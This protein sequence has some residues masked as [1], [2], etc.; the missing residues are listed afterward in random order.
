MIGVIGGVDISHLAVVDQGSIFFCV[1][2]AYRHVVA[3]LTAGRD[4]GKASR[5]PLATQS[6]VQGA[7]R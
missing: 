6:C 3:G 1:V 2:Q 5:R 7:Y 4:R